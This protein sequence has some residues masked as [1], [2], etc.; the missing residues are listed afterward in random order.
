MEHSYIVPSTIDKFIKHL[1]NAIDSEFEP[2]YVPV[3]VEN[4][5]EWGQCYYNVDEKVRRDGGKA[6]YGWALYQSKILSEAE[7]HAVWENNNG[8]LFDITP[9]ALG[10]DKIFFVSE[11]ISPIID[12]DNHRINRVGSASVDDFLFIAKTIANLDSS[13]GVRVSQVE[14]HLPENVRNYILHLRG[15]KDSY[16]DYLENN[17][18]IA[19][20]CYCGSAKAYKNCC[21]IKLRADIQSNLKRIK[22]ELAQHQ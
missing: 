5:S 15:L 18:S 12:I 10:V 8:D 1:L 13:Y 11:N 3:V 2:E 6:H 14:K 22:G 21:S 19:A 17:S 7:R 9:N 4:Y 20:K 16:S